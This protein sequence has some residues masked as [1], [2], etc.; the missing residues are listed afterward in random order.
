M[1]SPISRKTISVAALFLS[2]TATQVMAAK[3]IDV[4]ELSNGYPSGPHHNLNIHGKTDYLCDGTTGGGSVFVSEY[5]DSTISYVTNRKSGVTE[6]TALDKC[7]EAFDGTPAK[8]QIPYEQQGYYV[9]ADVKGKPNNGKDGE[10]SSVI[11]YPNLVREACNDTDPANPD[12]GTYTECPDSDQ[13]ALGLIVGDNVYEATDIGFVRFNDQT[14][15]G[16]G[17]SKATDI[18]SLFK[19]T[20]YV[21]DATLDLNLDG[22]ISVE[23]VPLS[24]DLLENGGNGNGIIDQAEFDLWL[25]DMEA[26]GLVQYYEDEWILNIADLVTTDQVISNDGIKLLK[27]RFYPVATTEYIT[28]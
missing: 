26:A 7:A 22:E 28:Q 18:T 1:R 19:Y 24:Y 25:L 20:G 3:P 21:F 9:F 6:L 13:L 5:G 2:L 8:V 16:K 4:I 17:K 10:E 27:I 12:F 23:D 14:S 15:G 11:L